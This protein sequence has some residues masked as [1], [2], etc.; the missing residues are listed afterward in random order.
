MTHSQKRKDRQERKTD[1]RIT[2]SDQESVLFGATSL[3]GKPLFRENNWFDENTFIDYVDRYT[4]I[5][6]CQ[7]FLDKA[8]QLTAQKGYNLRQ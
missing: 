7:V 4:E 8:K 1:F 2:G 3:E 6:K 5:S